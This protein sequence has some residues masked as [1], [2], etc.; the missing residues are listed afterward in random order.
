MQVLVRMILAA[1]LLTASGAVEA[2]TITGT[3]TGTVKDSS[4]GV[5]P[6]ATVTMTQLDTNRQQTAVTDPEGRYTSPPLQLGNYRVEAS[7]SGF[8]SALQS[9]V[10]LTLDEVARLDFVLGVGS[11]QEVVEVAAQASMVDSQT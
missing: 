9:G 3:I 1:A 6:G 2:Q 10:T 7:L 8:K 11:L 4:G 5:L